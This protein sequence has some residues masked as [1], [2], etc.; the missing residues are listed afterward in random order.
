MARRVLK[1]RSVLLSGSFLGTQHGVM[2]IS[3][4]DRAGFFE[5]KKYF[6]SQKIRENIVQA[7]V[8]FLNLVY[9]GSLN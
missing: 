9:N 2:P 4:Y 1:I 8:F 3:C 7:Y 6:R 5:K